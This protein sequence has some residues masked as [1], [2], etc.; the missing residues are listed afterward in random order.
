MAAEL[1]DPVL[2]MAHTRFRLMW[3]WAGTRASIM[4]RALDET[5]YVQPSLAEFREKRGA[6]TDYHF[7]YIRGWVV[8]PDGNVFFGVDA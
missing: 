2:P 8:E 4:S 7:N 6:G 5:G 3:Q 1:Q